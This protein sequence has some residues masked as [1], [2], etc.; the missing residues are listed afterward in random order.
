MSR[1]ALGQPINK[2]TETFVA[3]K[4][5]ALDQNNTLSSLI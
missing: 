1:G 4:T 2:A 3:E 5:N